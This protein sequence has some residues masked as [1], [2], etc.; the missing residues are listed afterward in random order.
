MERAQVLGWPAERVQVI[1]ADQG[2][3]GQDG[4][5]LGFQALVAEVSLGRVGVILA[6]EAS[7][8]ARSNADWYALLDLAALRHTLIADPD[9]VYDPCSYNDRLL[10]GLRGMLSEAELHLLRL[11]ME[12]G[13]LR[14]IERGEYRQQLPTGLVRL[15]DGRV[16]KDPDLQVQ[17]T[18]DLIFALFAEVGSCQ[19]VLRRFRDMGVRVP[20]R[21]TGGADA[22][23]ILWKAPSEAVIYEILHNPA[24]AGA[25]VYGRRAAPPERSIE[26]R[27]R[28]HRQA[29]DQWPT[30]HYNVYPGSISWETFMANQSRLADNANHYR[31]YTRGAAR[32]GAALLVGIAV[33][34]RCG[35]Q[36][37]IEYKTHPRY[38][39][40]ALGKEYG[41][42]ICLHVDA[43]SIDEAVVAAFFAAL[44]PA[45]LDLLE[46]VLAHQRAEQERWAQHHADQVRRATYEAHLAQ[47]QY[48][49]V[50]PDNR[51]VAAE[52]ERRW[53][54]ALRALEEAQE[55][56]HHFQATPGV[57]PALDPVV[58]EE[59]TAM[60][61][62]LPE[63]WS[64][65]QLT[66]EHQKS[67]LRS[68]I[69]RTILTRPQPDEVDA[70]VV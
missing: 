61:Q 44:A 21:Q 66:L 37:H 2:C 53:E 49:A 4:R 32:S 7:R 41:A 29:M 67:L 59:L 19:K 57:T 55:A 23:A 22:G 60:G 48:Q 63:L 5:R 68:L 8:L 42:S 65:G 1:D 34:G 25:F 62:Y 12:A 40:S 31:Q 10:L 33:C 3:S 30:I 24:Y 64:R 13:R 16:V 26:Q 58:R 69:R 51:L 18:L 50:D 20:R 15:P 17:H 43:P 14:Q 6:Y 38:V 47:R 54:L 9:G 28:R 45:E 52:L 46:E 36:L 70:T 11:R 56:E 27:D 35:R 39:C